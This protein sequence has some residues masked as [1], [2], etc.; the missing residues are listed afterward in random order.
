MSNLGLEVALNN[1]NIPFF[2]TKVG[3]RFIIEALK[4]NNWNLG[5]EASGHI[6]CLDAHN[7]GDGIISALKVLAVI[8]ATGRTLQDLKTDMEKY[9]QVMIN[10]KMLKRIDILNNKR[11]NHEVEY[12]RNMLSEG[13]RVLLRLSGTEPL[14]RVMVEGRDF[15][16]VNEI[17]K[18]LSEIVAAE[19]A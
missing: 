19:I 15:Q 6:L 1:L 17:A 3:D 7:T 16:Q 10:I 9:P 14:V 11:I 2:R 12:A 18:H 5:G 4:K 13:G 8:C